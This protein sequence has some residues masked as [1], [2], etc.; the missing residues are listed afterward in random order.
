LDHLAR[1][2]MS[3]SRSLDWSTTGLSFLC[4]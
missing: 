1:M 4:K 2:I 3:F